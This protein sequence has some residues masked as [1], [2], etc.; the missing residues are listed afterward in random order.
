M[1]TPAGDR[2]IS[3][4]H[5]WLPNSRP[6]S[7]IENTRISQRFSPVLKNIPSL[8]TS[9]VRDQW[10]FQSWQIKH[11]SQKPTFSFAKA[12][13]E[14]WTKK[15][16][17]HWLP[18]SSWQHQRTYCALHL[19][20]YLA[21]FLTN[22]PECSHRVWSKD[23]REGCNDMLHDGITQMVHKGLFSS[24]GGC[25]THTDFPHDSVFD[26]LWNKPPNEVEKTDR[27]KPLLWGGER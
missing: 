5:V 6:T 13:T 22:P 25:C 16:K 26:E 21:P 20:L 3:W 8:S 27:K 14:H 24:N 9:K 15:L 7:K 23:G 1:S 19:G 18:F 2:T 10:V 12:G 11:V 4:Q 17:L